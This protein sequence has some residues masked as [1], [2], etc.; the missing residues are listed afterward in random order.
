VARVSTN[1]KALCPK[2]HLPQGLDS[3]SYISTA[4]KWRLKHLPLYRLCSPRHFTDLRGRAG[5][6]SRSL[7]RRE[8]SALL[9]LDRNLPEVSISVGTTR[10]TSLWTLEWY[11]HRPRVWLR[12]SRR[13]S[14][15]TT[16]GAFN[17][18]PVSFKVPS[19]NFARSPSL[20]T[21]RRS[22]F[23]SLQFGNNRRECYW[24]M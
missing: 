14:T 19:V 23:T 20:P 4:V 24:R 18:A 2:S 8:A 7:H 3:V 10:A 17:A 9:Y 12:I 11:L 5:R 6:N 21:P 22:L 1:W 16:R 15:S 13:I